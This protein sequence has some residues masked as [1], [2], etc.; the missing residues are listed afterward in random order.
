VGL[1]LSRVEEQREG[2]KDES[3]EVQRLWASTPDG[4]FVVPGLRAVD[5]F[6]RSNG[7]KDGKRYRFLT[8]NIQQGLSFSTK[9]SSTVDESLALVCGFRGQ[10]F[11]D[12][13]L[14]LLD[15]R[16]R[17]QVRE[18]QGPRDADR[19]RYNHKRKCERLRALLVDG[20][21]IGPCGRV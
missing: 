5:R 6:S 13:C 14:Q 21:G 7:R 15:C 10:R 17:R 8:K 9:K 11:P 2:S 19:G 12:L 20:R 18:S 4:G 3:M 16:R 1:A